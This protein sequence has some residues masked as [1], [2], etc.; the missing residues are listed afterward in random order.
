MS[1]SELANRFSNYADAVVAFAVLNA[2]GFLSA[3]AEEDTRE[4][5]SEAPNLIF[6]ASILVAATFYTV[7]ALVF[8]KAELKLRA[9]AGEESTPIVSSYQ[10]RFQIA[11]ISVIWVSNGLTLLVYLGVR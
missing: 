3:V 11:R 8:R 1:P 9:E 7:L 6:M 2:V 5:I 4:A 10:R